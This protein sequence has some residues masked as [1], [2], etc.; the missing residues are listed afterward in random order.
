MTRHNRGRPH[1]TALIRRPRCQPGRPAK[2]AAEY[3]TD[4]RGGRLVCEHVRARTGKPIAA[5]PQLGWPDC[6][7]AGYGRAVPRQLSPRC[8]TFCVSSNACS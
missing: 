5:P 1:C 7:T 8:H 3:R 2:L 4:E 6:G